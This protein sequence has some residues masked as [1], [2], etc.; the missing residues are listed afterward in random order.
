MDRLHCITWVC[1]RK[2]KTSR[3]RYTFD[4]NI[5]RE[6]MMWTMSCFSYVVEKTKHSIYKM[7]QISIEDFT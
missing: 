5:S 7:I 2:T 6:H 3:K 1:N 4:V